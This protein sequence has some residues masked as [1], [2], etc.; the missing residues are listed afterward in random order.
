MLTRAE[1]AISNASFQ[2]SSLFRIL[3]L[4][5][6]TPSYTV[7]DRSFSFA[8]SH[9]ELCRRELECQ[10]WAELITHTITPPPFLLLIY[11]MIVPSF[12]SFWPFVDLVAGNFSN[13]PLNSFIL[14]ILQQRS[15]LLSLFNPHSNTIHSSS[16]FLDLSCLIDYP[17]WAHNLSS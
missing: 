9:H 13:L 4:I 5:Y 11:I 8:L 10:K 12:W 16:L 17:S 3:L 7:L 1:F 2:F 14:S 6:S 15:F